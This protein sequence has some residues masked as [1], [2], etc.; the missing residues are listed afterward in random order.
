M[1][2]QDRIHRAGFS[3]AVLLKRQ[4]VRGASF[5]GGER[6]IRSDKTLSL[7]IA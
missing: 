2:R 7:V 6:G 3:T 1:Q 5:E 4:I